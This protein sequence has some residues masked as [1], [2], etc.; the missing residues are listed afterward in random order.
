MNIPAIPRRNFWQVY[1]WDELNMSF[2]YDE[3]MTLNVNF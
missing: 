1:Y 3:E 2:P